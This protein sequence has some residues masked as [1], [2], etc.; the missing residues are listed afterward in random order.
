MSMA[1]HRTPLP[2]RGVIRLDGETAR[3]FLHALVTC[4]L[5][6]LEGGQAAYAALLTPQG[7]VVS[8]FLISL[9]PEDRGGGLLIDCPLGL[10]ETLI[11]ALTRYRLRSKV[12][13]D[14]LSQIIHVDAVWGGEPV[15][16]PEDLLSRDPRHPDLGWRLYRFADDPAPATATLADYD[17][18]R[19]ACLV[20]E[21]GREFI[22][23]DVFPHDINMDR[24]GGV[25]FDKGCYIGQEVVS[26][27]QHRGTARNRV[28]RVA[29]E[30][31][32]PEEGQEILVDGRVIGQM[33]SAQGGHGLARLRIDKV[34]D[35]VTAG[36]PIL[37]GGRSLTVET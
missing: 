9:I 7:K 1:P 30:V 19:I 10:V 11:T 13:I 32:A 28:V 15:S 18:L 26:R 37:S 5:R 27:M 3:D 29:Y 14:N 16:G 12:T 22:H 17:A 24:L 35:A 2:H 31:A 23:G 8:D 4:D 25:A 6:S 21:G 34:A 20:P 36:Q 33:G